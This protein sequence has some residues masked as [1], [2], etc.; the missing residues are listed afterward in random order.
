[1]VRRLGW[2]AV[3]VPLTLLVAA[4]GVGTAAGQPRPSAAGSAAPARAGMPARS[5]GSAATAAPTA[6]ATAAASAV[7]A[8]P[9][10][11]DEKA[12]AWYR[13]ALE[14]GKADNWSRAY[15][16]LLDAARLKQS[17]DILGNLG[18]AEFRLGRYRDAAEHFTASLKVYPVNG[19]PEGKAFSQSLLDEAKAQVGTLV[20]RITPEAA[21]VRVNAAEIAAGAREVVFVEPGEVTIEVGGLAGYEPQRRKLTV[22]KGKTETVTMGLGTVGVVGERSPVPGY[23]AG[24]IGVAGLV[25][26]AVLL[27]VGFAQ[28]GDVAAKMP[29]DENGAPLCVRSSAAG[30]ERHPDCATLRDAESS[31]QTMANVGLPMMIGSGVVVA[32]AIAYLFWP[33]SGP[34]SAPSTGKMVPVVGPQGAALVWTGSF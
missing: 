27:G 25:A 6:N 2:L 9:K 28:K 22:E 13:E 21:K 18:T 33:S 15:E 16:L 10:S 20:L 23:V 31:A 12:D 29:R 3:G 4:S 24:G 7:P 14:A 8:A 5:S 19:R 26:G 32:G 1:M 34:K 11:D 30:P 17:H